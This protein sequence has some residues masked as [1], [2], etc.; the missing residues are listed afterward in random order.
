MTSEECAYLAGLLDGEGTIGARVRK[1]GYLNL[2]LGVCMTTP[3]PLHWAQETTGSGGIYF[4]P[5]HRPNRQDAWFWKV[6]RMEEIAIILR[7][8][9]PYLKVKREEAMLFL[10]LVEFRSMPRRM[11]AVERHLADLISLHKRDRAAG[12]AGVSLLTAI[13][14]KAA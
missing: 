4:R 12:L 1:D 13:L 9:M 2:E 3:A 11:P 6:G 5:E 7:E 8:V 14:P 10:T